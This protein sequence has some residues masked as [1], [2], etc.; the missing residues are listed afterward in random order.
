MS[1]WGDSWGSAWGDAWDAVD[2][3]AP[4]VTYMGGGT[5][6]GGGSGRGRT[7]HEYEVK[8]LDARAARYNQIA[9]AT[10]LALLASG[11]I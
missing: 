1:A 11:S 2:T 10:V 3:A 9:I 4:V 8:R 7:V 6:G 5:W